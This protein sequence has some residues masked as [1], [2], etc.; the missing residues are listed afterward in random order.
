MPDTIEL[1][2]RQ[3]TG[4]HSAEQRNQFGPLPLIE[5]LTSGV[6]SLG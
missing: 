6:E 5:R 4:P 2:L 3:F 1:D